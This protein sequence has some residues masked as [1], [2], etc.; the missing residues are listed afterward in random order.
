MSKWKDL[1]EV[2]NN[3]PQERL[4]LINANGFK[5]G[6]LAIVVISIVLLQ[7]V[8]WYISFIFLVQIVNNWV[9]YKR[10]MKSYNAIIE[11]RKSMGVYQE[12]D[13]D[14]SF[15]RRR[16]RL[17][18]S[19]LGEASKYVILFLVAMP[20]ALYTDMIYVGLLK[21]F[22][23]LLIIIISFLWVY[24]YPTYWIAKGVRK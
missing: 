20:I 9:G 1:K 18:A 16:F 11:A 4:C 22:G 23:I 24:L 21:R 12:I 14:P 7:T 19:V 3:P 13:E 6:I 10:E 2:M 8:I 17:N 15:T 5:M